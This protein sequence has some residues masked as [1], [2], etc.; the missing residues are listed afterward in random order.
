MKLLLN[1]IKAEKKINKDINKIKQLENLLVRIKYADNP[2][3][4]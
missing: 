1:K 3:K 4:L 2:N